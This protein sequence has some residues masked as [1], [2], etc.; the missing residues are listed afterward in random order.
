MSI[1]ANAADIYNDT[2]NYINTGACIYAYDYVYA[3]GYIYTYTHTEADV[4]ARVLMPVLMLIMA[5]GSDEYVAE[6]R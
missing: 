5:E 6:N 4:E 1:P 2:Y 3:Y